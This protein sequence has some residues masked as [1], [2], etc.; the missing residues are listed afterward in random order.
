[1]GIIIALQGYNIHMLGTTIAGLFILWSVAPAALVAFA[2]RRW[3]QARGQLNAVGKPIDNHPFLVG[4]ILGTVSC[5]VSLVLFI[6]GKTVD[7]VRDVGAII[8]FAAAL[9]ALSI[10]PFGRNKAKWM[11]ILACAM[12][13]T[14]AP[15]NV[16]GGWL[17]D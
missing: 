8:S 1:M 6:P 15:L 16:F 3:V 7:Q 11:T 17:L 9:I 14:L 12:T 2:W 5:C 10:L 13:A 4:Q